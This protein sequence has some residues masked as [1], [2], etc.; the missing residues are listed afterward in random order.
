M[1]RADRPHGFTLVEALVVMAIVAV[2]VA[3]AWP[4]LQGHW[5]RARRADAVLALLQ[6]QQQQLRWRADHARYADATELGAPGPSPDGHFRLAVDAP[7]LHGFTLVARAD[8]PQRADRPCATFQL[9]QQHADTRLQSFTA[10]GR[11]NTA[12][13]NRRC[14]GR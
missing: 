9:V 2:L 13:E 12:T 1:C 10:D 6:L 5:L 14:W 8:G 11:A 4:S 7:D 3:L